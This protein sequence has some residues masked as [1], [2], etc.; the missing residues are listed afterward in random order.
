[1][2]N[3]RRVVALAASGHAAIAGGANRQTFPPTMA[4][5]TKS[6]KELPNGREREDECADRPGTALWWSVVTFFME[7]FAVYGASMH[8]TAAFSVE[9]VLTAARRPL[10]WSARR[11]PIAAAHERVSYLISENGNVIRLDRVAAIPLSQV[12]GIS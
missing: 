10:P 1:M 12:A 6:P 7:G 3:T 9:A 5:Q 2:K 11:T 8:P 4:A